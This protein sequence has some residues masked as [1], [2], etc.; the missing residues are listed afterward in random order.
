[1]QNSHYWGSNFIGRVE[2]ESSSKG[3]VKESDKGSSKRII[4]LSKN[5]RKHTDVDEPYGSK[6]TPEQP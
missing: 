2:K 4:P 3:T 5:S 6:L 1:M